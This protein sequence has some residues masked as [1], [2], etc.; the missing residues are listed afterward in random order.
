MHVQKR[1]KVT[2]DARQY[3]LAYVLTL[4]LTLTL[5]TYASLSPTEEVQLLNGLPNVCCRLS[6]FS[7]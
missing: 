6:A 4:T 1:R 2:R 7:C 3:V 5:T